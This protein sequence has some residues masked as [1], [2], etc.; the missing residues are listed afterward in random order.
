MALLNC[1]S[2]LDLTYQRIFAINTLLQESCHNCNLISNFK[3]ID[4]I[5]NSHIV[6]MVHQNT[7]P[8]FLT[9][10]GPNHMGKKAYWESK[11]KHAEEQFYKPF[12]WFF[13]FH[14]IEDTLAPYLTPARGHE[15]GAPFRLLDLGCGMSD[16]ALK[17]HKSINFKSEIHCLDFVPSAVNTLCGQNLEN[18]YKSDHLHLSKMLFTVA[19]AQYLP[20]TSHLFDVLVDKGTTDAVLKDS[21]TGT[22]MAT[23]IIGEALR[24]LKPG[25]HMLQLTDEDP[26]LRLPLIEAAAKNTSRENSTSFTTLE[27]GGAIEYFMYTIKKV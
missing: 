20:Y 23:R 5:H 7:S 1:F 9:G 14:A 26:D 15:S 4:A 8:F 19:D 24:V 13:N 10:F 16:F 6:F 11:Y 22:A 3:D 25:G 12:D 17:L 18:T 21:Q 2:V 27:V